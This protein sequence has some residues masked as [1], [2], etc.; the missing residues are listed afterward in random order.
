FVECGCDAHEARSV[1]DRPIPGHGRA[2][3]PK[4]VI[5]LREPCE[6]VLAKPEIS[7]R[8]DGQIVEPLGMGSPGFVFFLGSVQSIQGKLAND[9]QHAEARPTQWARRLIDKTLFDQRVETG[10][11]IVPNVVRLRSDGGRCRQGESTG[12]NGQPAKERLLV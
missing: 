9:L 11:R 6:L 4:L 3:I 5:D 8:L 10:P 12:K 7:F 1:A 2:Q